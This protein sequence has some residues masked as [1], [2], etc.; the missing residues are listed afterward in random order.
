MSDNRGTGL[1]LTIARQ[2][3]EAEE[4]RIYAHS[5]ESGRTITSQLPSHEK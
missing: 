2:L 5:D 3:V 1:G 4:G